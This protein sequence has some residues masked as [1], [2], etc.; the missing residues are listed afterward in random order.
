MKPFI[1]NRTDERRTRSVGRIVLYAL[2]FFVVT[3]LAGGLLEGIVNA[4]YLF[5]WDMNAMDMLN[6]FGSTEATAR[7]DGWW[8]L[9]NVLVFA[10]LFEESSFRLGLSFRRVHV[11]VGLG[12][13]TTFVIACCLQSAGVGYLVD[14]A[15]ALPSG[16]AVGTG[17]WFFTTDT[18]WLSKRDRWQRP[19]MWASAI[20]FGLAHLFAMPGLTWALLPMALVTAFTLALSGC[21]L[22][23]L[24]VNLGF[25]WGV[26]AHAIINLP[27][28]F[29][30]LRILLG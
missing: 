19:M 8:V 16:I 25:W 9:L 11:A 4:V 20:L 13:L 3:R 7:Q 22:V 18:F 2:L 27:G 23:Y 1:L 21:M 29:A 5:G 14:W 17:L 24:R 15:W 12:V 30:L 28:T 6:F 26:G 10:P